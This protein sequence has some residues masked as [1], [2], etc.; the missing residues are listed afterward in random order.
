MR[1]SAFVISGGQIDMQPSDMLRHEAI[2]K[3]RGEDVVGL[4]VERALLDVGDVALQRLIEIRIHR[5]G[6]DAFAAVFAGLGQRGE[7][8]V[9]IAERAA[10]A[11]RQRHT[12]APV[13]VA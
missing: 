10:V 2:E 6:P 12:Q 9:A 3:A 4:A 13:S 11:R 7:Q 5:E 1:E 8:I